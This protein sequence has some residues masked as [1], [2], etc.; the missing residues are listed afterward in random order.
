MNDRLVESF[1]S[2][3]ILPLTITRIRDPLAPASGRGR[4]VR[5]R[6]DTPGTLRHERL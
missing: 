2:F 1:R 4:R 5:G 6:A 3:N